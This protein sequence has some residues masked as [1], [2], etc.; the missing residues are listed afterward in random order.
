[1]REEILCIGGPLDREY[2]EYRGHHFVWHMPVKEKP[3][4]R[5]RIESRFDSI[6]VHTDEYKIEELGRGPRRYAVYVARSCRNYCDNFIEVLLLN[7][8]KNKDANPY[9]ESEL[10]RHMDYRRDDRADA[11][12]FVLD[13]MP[14]PKPKPKPPEKLTI[15]ERKPTLVALPK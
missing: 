4:G 6:H 2:I 7:Y 3:H 13:A 12:K 1:M 10:L 15:D 8:A 9:R 11:M 14:K 5:Y